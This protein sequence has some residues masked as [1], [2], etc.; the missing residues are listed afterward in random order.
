MGSGLQQAL[1]ATRGASR[2]LILG[3]KADARA[4]LGLPEEPDEVPWIMDVDAYATA[5]GEVFDVG[6]APLRID[7]FNTA[8][9]WLKGLEFAARGVYFVR[10]PSAEYERLGLGMRAR[11][12]RDWAKFVT[13]GIQDADRRREH[14][15]RA[16]EAV[17]AAHLT[18]HTAPG[19]VAAW[20]Q[21]VDN[22]VRSRRKGA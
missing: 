19:W 17:L 14:A 15:V 12:P 11:S 7:R 13:L 4:R 9:S 20:Q 21:A 2:F 10:S 3:Q 22:R 18:E 16:R 8:K 5:V 6:V 1:D